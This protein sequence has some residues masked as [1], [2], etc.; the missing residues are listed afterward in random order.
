MNNFQQPTQ[1]TNP[2]QRNTD[3]LKNFFSKPIILI[4]AIATLITSISAV[5]FTFLFSSYVDTIATITLMPTNSSGNL[6]VSIT[7]MSLILPVLTVVCCILIFTYS[8]NKSPNKTPSTP[9]TILWVVNI[10]GLILF[11]IAIAIMIMIGLIYFAQN[12]VT[13]RIITRDP[14]SILVLG[15][16]AV[17]VIVALVY[18]VNKIRY[19]G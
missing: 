16:L 1:V 4:F 11:C 2:Y 10:I 12:P 17:A 18:F 14:A 8:R 15:F 19:L 13:Y 9:I 6:S 3:I 7:P 5:F